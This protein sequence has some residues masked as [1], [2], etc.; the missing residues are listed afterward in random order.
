MNDPLHVEA[1]RVAALLHG[2]E[3]L[4]LNDR[5]DGPDGAAESGKFRAQRHLVAA[6]AERCRCP[7]C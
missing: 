5:T 2:N 7:A 4:V 6:D 1:D 3:L